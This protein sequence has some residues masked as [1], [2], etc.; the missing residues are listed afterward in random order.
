MYPYSTLNESKNE[1]RLL[2]LLPRGFDQQSHY[3]LKHAELV[4]TQAFAALSY[5]WGDPTIK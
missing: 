2:H 4:E 3:S 5:T 1:I